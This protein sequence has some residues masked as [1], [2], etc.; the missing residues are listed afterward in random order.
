MKQLV[1]LRKA[2][3]QIKK[4]NATVVV[5][6]REDKLRGEGLKKTA[7][8]TKTDFV[9]LDDFGSKA[10][11]NYSSGSFSVYIIDA[12]GFLRNILAGTKTNRPS[13][14]KVVARLGEIQKK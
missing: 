9:F 3:D 14:D 7:S 4:L 12:D 1:Q 11:P 8:N 5:V 10:T 2:S 6:Q 13:A